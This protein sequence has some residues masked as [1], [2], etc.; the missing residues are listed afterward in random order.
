VTSIRRLLG[1]IWANPQAR[2][3]VLLS[4]L[5]ML[6]QVAFDL[7]I[8]LAILQTINEGILAADFDAVL[9][10]SFGIAVFSLGS[11][12]FAVGNVWFGASLSEQ[13]GHL[14]RMVGYRK[15][16][17]LSWGNVDRLQTSDLLVRLTT[18]VNQV[19]T[20]MMGS[21]TTLLR[22]PVMVVGAVLILVAVTPQLA[23]IMLVV[24]PLILIV[25]TAY[26]LVGNPRYRRTLAVFDRL[27]LVLQENLA[28]VRAV[29]AFGREGYENGRFGGRNDEM[30]TAALSAGRVSALLMPTLVLIINLALAAVLWFGGSD[31]IDAGSTSIG[32]IIMFLNYVFA[33]MVPLILLSVLLPQIASATS[34]LDR[35]YQLFD[36][37]PDVVD[38]PDA[39]SLEVAVGGEI[40]GRVAFEGVRFSY[41]TADGTPSPT[42]VLDGIDLVAE[43]GQVVAI[44]GATGSGK[45]SLVNLIIRAYDVTAGRVTIDGVDI[46]EVSRESLLRTVVPVLQQPTLF[47]GTV[48]ENLRLGRPDLDDD[49]LEAAARMSEA[50]GFI[51]ERSEAYE[52]EVKRRGANFSGGQRQRLSIA[53]A[54]ARAPRILILDDATGALDVATEARVQDAMRASLVGTTVFLVAQRVSSVLTADRVVLLEEGRISDQGT[55]QELLG[56][57]ALYQE[58]Y[59]SQLGEPAHA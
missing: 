12:A 16:L 7:L 52:D 23:W 34:S 32:D 48:G 15:V 53:R 59:R 17:A 20:V 49:A 46:R 41:L 57:S 3:W 56:R 6:G 43:P 55:H 42:A 18:D 29:K 2:R 11:A 28:G 51:R 31:V 22:A 14:I 10:G 47:S 25:L 45:S 13:G 40:S 5:C 38:R 39:P 44:L 9:R 21:V 58:I 35:L 36:L 26:Q 4:Q 33:I 8:P 54:L 50:D 37:A 24:L 27:N 30:R 19:K 1:A